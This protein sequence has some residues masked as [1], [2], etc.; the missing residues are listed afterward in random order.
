VSEYEKK[1]PWNFTVD[2]YIKSIA[3]SHKDLWMYITWELGLPAATLLWAESEW[4]IKFNQL[5]LEQ[6]I[7][8]MS[9]RN[10]IEKLESSWKNS[11]KVSSNEIISELIEQRKIIFNN[12]WKEF[13]RIVWEDPGNL[14][15]LWLTQLEFDKLYALLQDKWIIIEEEHEDEQ[16][17]WW[18]L[19]FWV[20]PA[21]KYGW[22]FILWALTTLWIMKSCD[23]ET[24]ST[25]YN[26]PSTFSHPEFLLRYVTYRE[27]GEKKLHHEE[28]M[29]HTSSD[30]GILKT[31]RDGSRNF[32]Y[33]EKEV[34]VKI[35]WD[36]E[37]NR[38]NKNVSMNVDRNGTLQVRVNRPIVCAR[39]V[40]W[41]VM[42]SHWS[43][44][45]LN[46][47]DN[48]ELTAMK[49][50]EEQMLYDYVHNIGEWHENWR[51]FETTAKESLSRA[52]MDMAKWWWRT[53]VKRVNIVF[54]Q[55]SQTKIDT[56][57]EHAVGNW[58]DNTPHYR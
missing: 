21:I 50:A 24:H 9:L 4:N 57:S 14:K 7:N 19:P 37:I 25:T 34:D 51:D 16:K 29:Y 13:D 1:L 54:N 12:A 20:I 35:V 39:N 17:H 6:K 30:A 43:I 52:L 33:W 5:N 41:H 27:F 32:L 53:D 8:F 22:S 10:A 44:I 55:W 46:K 31:L 38:D 23:N 40:E 11:Q 58:W 48:T 49:L 56:K 28:R 15:N 3:E 2:W 42:K 36:I 45:R 47:F 26:W 18:P